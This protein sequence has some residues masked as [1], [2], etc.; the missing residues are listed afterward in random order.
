M[1]GRRWARPTSSPART[2]GALGCCSSAW[3]S[4]RPRLVSYHE[5]NEAER[6]GQLAQQV[7]RGAKVTLISEAGTP[8]I[9]DPGSA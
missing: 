1:P 8:V 5:G 7:E 9:S 2:P 4:R 6:A 3:T